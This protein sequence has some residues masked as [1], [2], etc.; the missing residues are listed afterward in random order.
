MGLRTPLYESHL[1]A[2]AKMVDFGGWD[3]PLHYGSQIEEHHQVRRD[4]G[5]FDVSHMTV[6]EVLG[7]QSREYLQY[8]LANDVARLTVNGKALYTAMLNQ[9]AGVLDD[10]LVYRTNAGYRLVL[11]AA[12]RDKDLAWMRRQAASFAVTLTERDDLAMLAIQGPG[13]LA[14]C[15]SAVSASR[16]ALI[17]QLEPFHGAPE[18]EWFIARTGYTGEDGLE[19]MLPAAEA[20]ALWSELLRSGVKP[21]GLGAR[22]TLRLE[23]GLNLYG[24]DLDEQ[25]SPLAANM[26][27]TIAWE[28]GSR[29]FIG[30]R[31]LEAQRQAGDQPRQVGLV[32]RERAVL[33]GGQPVMVDGRSVGQITSGSFSP[34]LGCSIA[35]ARVPRDTGS[36]A[37]VEVRG[38]LLQVQVVRPGFVR[39]GR[40][41]I[42]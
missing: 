15:A 20:P 29:D 38:K 34:T 31:V 27:W 6:V 13:A 16:A 18:G 32:L 8:L 14:A 37:Q 2:G 25:H 23:A 40:S 19:I 28:P 1:A 4:V 36:T 35:L 7:A 41:L 30:R 3:L 10:L 5:M 22:D 39:Q 42:D 12:T 21:C 9:D 33:R 17:T 24:A 26:A 11:N